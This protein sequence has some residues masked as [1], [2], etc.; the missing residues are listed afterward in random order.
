[1]DIATCLQALE[2]QACKARLSKARLEYGAIRPTSGWS[3]LM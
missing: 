2:L 1:M 3:L